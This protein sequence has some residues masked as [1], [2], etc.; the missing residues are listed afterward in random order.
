MSCPVAALPVITPMAMP[1][2][3]TNQRLAMT[4]ASTSAAQPVPSPVPKP[5]TS[6]RCHGSEIASVPPK[7]R[8]VTRSAPSK[9]LRRPK[10]STSPAEK[11]PINP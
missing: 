7:D 9:I 4:A 2:C 3:A 8:I 11:G 5:H 1:R 6:D 10:R